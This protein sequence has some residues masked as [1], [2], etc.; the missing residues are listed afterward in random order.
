MEY[1]DSWSLIMDD[2][3]LRTVWQQ[4]QFNDRAARVGEPLAVLM[5]HKL[6][7]RVRQLS[8]LAV[9]WDEVVPAQIREHTALESFSAGVL[10][11]VVDSAPHRFQL[12]T[13][14]RGGLKHAIQ[15]GFSGSLNKVRLV[16]GQ[17]ASVDLSG[18]RRYE[19]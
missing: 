7:R 18:A 17:F 3:Q 14:L 6:E 11:V 13:M 4:K 5:K 19:F 16:P 12:E 15:A 8:R 9:V 1:G 2:A 10:T